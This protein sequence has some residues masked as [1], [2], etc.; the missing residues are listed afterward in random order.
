LDSTGGARR[1]RRFN[2]QSESSMVI[3]R[4]SFEIDVEAG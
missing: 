1:S 3:L 4:S 2:A